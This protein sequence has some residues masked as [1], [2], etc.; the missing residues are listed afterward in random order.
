MS[1]SF[2]YVKAKGIATEDEYPYT[3]EFRNARKMVG[4]SRSAAQQISRVV[5]I[6]P[7]LFR[8]VPFRLLLM[9]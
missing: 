2:K 7:M 4:P 5:I 8:K 9:P 1:N 6:L 3:L